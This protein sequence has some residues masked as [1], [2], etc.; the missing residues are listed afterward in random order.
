MT[1]TSAS[2]MGGAERAVGIVTAYCAATEGLNVDPFSGDALFDIIDE[3][4]RG[5]QQ[6]STVADRMAARLAVTRTFMAMASI[7]AALLANCADLH[8]IDKFEM[9]SG[10]AREL[11]GSLP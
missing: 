8:E 6:A 2:Q 9:L 3:L 5:V 7:S 10:L 1:V 11:Y 4:I